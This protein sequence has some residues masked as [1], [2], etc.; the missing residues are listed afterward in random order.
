MPSM[1]QFVT[2]RKIALQNIALVGKLESH[3]PQDATQGDPVKTVVILIQE[4]S[5]SESR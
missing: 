2:A 5:P 1:E 3:A 4:K